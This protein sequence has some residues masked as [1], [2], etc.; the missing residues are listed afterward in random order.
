[1]KILHTSDWHLGKI[2]HDHLLIEDQVYILDKLVKFIGENPH[3]VLII[4]GDIYDRSIPPKEA[5][6]AFSDFICNLRKISDIPLVII[7]GNHDSAHRLSYLSE[8]INMSD[9]FIKWDPENIHIPVRIGNA[10][11]YAVPYLDPYA[12]DIHA[13][14]EERQ[15]RTHENALKTAVSMI[16]DVM[17]NERLN[18]FVGHLFTRGCKVSDSERKFIGTSGEVDASILGKFD[19]CALGH[20]HRP[21]EAEEK[22][23]YSGSLLKYSF[24]EANDE[25]RVLSIEL[26]KKRCEVENIVID[27]LRPLSCITGLLNDLINDKK[28]EKYKGHYLEIEIEN[29]GLT[30]NPFRELSKKFDNILSIKR[31]ESEYLLSGTEIQRREGLDISDDFESFQDY[32]HHEDNEL[33]KNK[34]KLFSDYLKKKQTMEN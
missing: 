8:I 28:Y 1:M 12:Y 16:E 20:L 3:D 30:L 6:T 24:S 14:A 17:A 4:S 21:Q 26:E 23:R 7:P 19:Y 9:I 31:K 33:L 25:K 13:D 27:P 22:I 29:Q 15:E 34:K 32:I 10:D 18:I 11:I 5:V 2:L